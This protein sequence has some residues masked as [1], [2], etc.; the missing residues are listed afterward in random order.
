MLKDYLL[1][2]KTTCF[3]VVEILDVILREHLEP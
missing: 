2:D 3:V 1:R